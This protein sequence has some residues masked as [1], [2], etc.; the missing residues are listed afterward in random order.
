MTSTRPAWVDIN[1]KT[2]EFIANK[3]AAKTVHRIY[4]MVADGMGCYTVARR[5]QPIKKM[6]S[7]LRYPAARNLTDG[8]SHASKPSSNRM[9]H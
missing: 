3:Q 7:L 4:E 5:L 1:P 9:H 2:G 6:A 8:I